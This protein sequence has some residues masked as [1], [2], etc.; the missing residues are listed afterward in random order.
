MQLNKL[1]HIA[2][3][4]SD[5]DVSKKFY[6][7]I[8]GLP[9]INETF[10]TDRKSHKLDLAVGDVQ[11]EL[12]TFPN[13]PKRTS[14]PEALGLRHLAFAVPSVKTCRDELVSKDLLVEEIRTDETTGK[15]FFFFSDPDGLPIEIYEAS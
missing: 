14:Y 4:A 10:R 3:I 6:T 13:S 8:L 7:E 11:I 15:R 1:H 5:Y 9:I 2:I 12:F